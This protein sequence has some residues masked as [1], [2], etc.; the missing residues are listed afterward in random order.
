MKDTQDV[1]GVEGGGCSSVFV[2]VS[3]CCVCALPRGQR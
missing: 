1:M 3:L 2:S